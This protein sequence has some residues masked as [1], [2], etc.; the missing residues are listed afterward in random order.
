MLIMALTSAIIMLW[1]KRR[2]FSIMFRNLKARFR[3]GAPASTR[4]M[5]EEAPAR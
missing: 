3:L 1:R 2:K 5:T 4:T